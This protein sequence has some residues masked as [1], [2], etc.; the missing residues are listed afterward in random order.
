MKRLSLLVTLLILAMLSAESALASTV[1]YSQ[2]INQCCGVLNGG[3]FSNDP[4]QFVVDL[5]N[6]SGGGSI[7]QAMW[8]GVAYNGLG[9]GT[10]NVEFFAGTGGTPG[11]P[12]Y[13]FTAAPTIVDTGLQDPYGL[14]LYQFTLNIPAF[15]AVPGLNYFFFAGD[16]GPVNFAW[17]NSTLTSGAF[18]SDTGKNGPWIDLAGG[19]NASQAFT[20]L[21]T[22]TTPE[23]GTLIM[24]GSGIIGLAGVLR[25]RINL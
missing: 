24:L 17:E 25:R 21:N 5:F 4:V 23:P 12:L 13:S 10:F 19:Y 20:L 18:Y 8:Y 14:E 22:G 3:P 2:P 1:L 15:T 11:A 16:T 9:F 7:N 6:L